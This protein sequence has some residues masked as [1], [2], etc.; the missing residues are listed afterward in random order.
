MHAAKAFGFIF[1][2]GFDFFRVTL[3]YLA[4]TQEFGDVVLPTNE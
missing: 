1:D 2:V 4:G 3:S